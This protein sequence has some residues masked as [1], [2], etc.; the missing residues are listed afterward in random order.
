MVGKSVL[1]QLHMILDREMALVVLE[2]DILSHHKEADHSILRK[3][4]KTD[5]S[6]G[7]IENTVLDISSQLFLVESTIDKSTPFLKIFN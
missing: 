4:S 3:S 7:V 6:T 1:V 5:F 2:I